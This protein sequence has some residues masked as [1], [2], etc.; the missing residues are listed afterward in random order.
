[1]T[2]SN[3]RSSNLIFITIIAAVSAG[4]ALRINGIFTT[5]IWYDESLPFAVGRL[6]FWSMLYA[7]RYTDAPPLW[8]LIV[9]WSIRVLGQ[10]EIALRLPSLIASVFI[11]WLVYKISGEFNLNS[12]QKAVVMVFICLLPYQIWIAQ[13]GRSYAIFS[14]LYLGGA[15]FAL[16]GRWLGLTACSGLILYSHY[17]G[18][19][20]VLSLYI[21]ASLTTGMSFKN[22]K[23]LI[24][25][26]VVALLSFIPWMP[27][28]MATLV[29]KIA[30]PPL[31]AS[32]LLGMFYRIMFADALS[33]SALLL[34]GLIAIAGCLLLSV[35]VMCIQ[36][37]KTIK[38]KLFS[39]DQDGTDMGIRY[40]Q[41]TLI[42]LLPLLAMVIWSVVWKNFI[43]YRLLVPLAIPLI[44]WALFSLAS[45]VSTWLV[46]YLFIPL[47]LILLL[48]GVANWSPLSRDGNLHH[49]IDMIN[50]QWEPGD[51]IYHI[52]GTSYMP[53]SNYTANKPMYLIDEQQHGWL[54]RPQL[55]DIFR[56]KR[57]A[58]ED[59]KYKRVWIVYASSEKLISGSARRRADQYIENGVLIDVVQAWQF[60]PIKVYLVE[61]KP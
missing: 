40:I 23:S 53:F 1:M 48:A 56:I 52:T 60:A 4:I 12:L 9:W 61:N 47:W 21:T 42:A 36:I 49:A 17:A 30:V 34:L 57:S 24:A 26:G 29:E 35:L 38:N 14:A 54:L 58:L 2:E 10:N 20:Y 37:Y 22:L 41:L 50:M 18:P 32:D 39:T 3:K 16:R 33:Q 13:D 51:I 11:L 44:L 46:K 5:G 27:T 45:Y 28:Y 59:I 8:D 31:T 7:T 15:W 43:Y 6:P 19:F 55:Q 25:S